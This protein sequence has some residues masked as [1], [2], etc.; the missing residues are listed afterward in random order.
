MTEL[1]L[2]DLVA[3]RTMSP[4]MAA[5][6][7]CAA[8]ER[9]SMLFVAIP[10]MAGKSTVMRAALQH[11]PA[12]T[13][14]HAL[15][16]SSGPQ[17][18]IPQQ[19]DGGYLT[20]SEIAHGGYFDDYLSGGEVQTVF[21]ALERGFSLA[22]ALHAPGIEEA[23]EV[24]R[25]HGVPDPEAGHIELVT[26]IRSFGHWSNP[27]RRVVEKIWEVD[28]VPAGNVQSR[29]LHRWVEADDGFEPVDEAARIGIRGGYG[30]MVDQFRKER[31]A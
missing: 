7:A 31:D 24:I 27:E 28:G 20:M 15:A 9:R 12:G 10:R 18:G 5:T 26:Y 29:L 13:P 25:Q 19:A 16:R 17:L 22:T 2:S 21:A 3:N 30:E 1:T 8:A 4:E 14:I 6:L 23:F 11:V